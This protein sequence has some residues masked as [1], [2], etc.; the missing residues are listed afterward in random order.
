[1]FKDRLGGEGGAEGSK[2]GAER[3]V[4]GGITGEREA[5]V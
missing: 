4:R 3:K 1:M 2:E 5:K